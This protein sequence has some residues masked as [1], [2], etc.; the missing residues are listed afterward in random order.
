MKEIIIA[1]ARVIT[2]LAEE[3]Q[4]LM[5]LVKAGASR[6]FHLIEK[7]GRMG[8]EIRELRRQLQR[9]GM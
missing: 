8:N 6:E 4:R 3:N 5:A 7:T 9:R 1:Q 2:G